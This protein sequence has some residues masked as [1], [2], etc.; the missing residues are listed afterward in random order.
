MKYDLVEICLL[1]W[2]HP[3][4]FFFN[5]N[6]LNLFYYCLDL[7]MLGVQELSKENDKLGWMVS[8]YV[9]RLNSYFLH[10]QLQHLLGCSISPQGSQ[11]FIAMPVMSSFHLETSRTVWKL[12]SGM[13]GF[14]YFSLTCTYTY[15]TR[16][17]LNNFFC[18]CLHSLLL[19]FMVA[20]LDSG[21]SLLA[22]HPQLCDWCVQSLLLLLIFVT[23]CEKRERL[24][25][26]EKAWHVKMEHLACWISFYACGGPD[27]RCIS[28]EYPAIHTKLQNAMQ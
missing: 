11:C 25:Q 3:E 8:D 15:A 6:I 14:K 21:I 27:K 2:K 12:V 23:C 5:L 28:T 22:C 4:F 7:W 19:F 17:W 26:W 16:D 10:T 1:F 13:C 9:M 18:V 24:K 20:Q